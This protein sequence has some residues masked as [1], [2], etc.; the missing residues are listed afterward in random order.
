MLDRFLMNKMNNA[1]SPVLQCLDFQSQSK[2]ETS[3]QRLGFLVGSS[4]GAR[5]PRLA[6]GF[7]SASLSD[8]GGD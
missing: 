1:P 6:A 3:I 2:P 8:G 4:H 7:P 5:P